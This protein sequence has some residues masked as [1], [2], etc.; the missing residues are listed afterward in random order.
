M[1]SIAMEI[2]YAPSFSQWISR[3]NDIM[4]IENLKVSLKRTMECSK[5]PGFIG[6]N[7][8]RLGNTPF[9]LVRKNLTLSS[10]NALSL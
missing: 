9:Y 2:S 4:Q 7:L 5:K 6:T 10:S 8:E 1:H 3:V